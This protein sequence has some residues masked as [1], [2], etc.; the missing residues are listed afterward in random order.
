MVNMD[1]LI[2]LA[3][4]FLIIGGITSYWNM[5]RN[6]KFK[7]E[8]IGN[9]KIKKGGYDYDNPKRFF[10]EPLMR[11]IWTPM[12]SILGSLLI[13]GITLGIFH[14]DGGKWFMSYVGNDLA[15]YLIGIPFFVGLG[16]LIS[17]SI[18]YPIR[19][20]GDHEKWRMQ[21]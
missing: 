20:W 9:Y 18:L 8:N 4:S 13:F 21:Y 2:Y 1:S 10:C 3:I 19:G 6:Q 17:Y 7:M 14:N 12:A 5:K 11:Y 16:F 15:N